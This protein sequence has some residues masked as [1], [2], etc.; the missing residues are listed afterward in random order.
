MRVH[1]RDGVG[2][3]HPLRRDGG[4][5]LHVG[6]GHAQTLRRPWDDL[7][8]AI[9]VEHPVRDDWW[10]ERNLIPLLDRIQIPVYLGCDWQNVPLHL[11]GTLASINALPNSPH[12]RIAMLGG[13]GMSWPWE[14][15]HVEALAWYDQWLKGRDTGILDG[16]RIRWVL[17]GADGWQTAESWPLPGT[18]PRELALHADGTLGADEGDPGHQTYMT[19]GAGLNRARPS[20]AR[21][22]Q[23]GQRPLPGDLDVIGDLELRIDAVASAADTAWIALVQDIAPDGASDEVTAGYLRTSLREVDD[24]ASQPGAPALLCRSARAVP[25]NQP[26]H[27]RAAGR[28]RP[29]VPRRAPHPARPH[30]R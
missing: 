20:P 27:S 22:A 5:D 8:R 29:A 25:I 15:L 23:L 6:N 3:R 12:V 10:D 11:P 28:Q 2:D 24:A 17:P 13:H 18:E 30:K 21:L 4:D 7:W 9:A 26:A 19:L 16:P 14:S 1:E